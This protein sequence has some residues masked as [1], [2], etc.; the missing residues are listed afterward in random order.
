MVK[1][2]GKMGEKEKDL[3]QPPNLYSK[4]VKQVIV[5]KNSHR[6]EY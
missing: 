1:K 3:D 5:E 6:I 2:I 4:P